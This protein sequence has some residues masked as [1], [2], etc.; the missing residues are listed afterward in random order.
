MDMD[1]GAVHVEFVVG[2][3]AVGHAVPSQLPFHKYS[4][5][6]HLSLKLTMFLQQKETGISILP[7]CFST[8]A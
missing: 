2:K 5:F 6:S 1:Y 4:I 7:S 8:G 3:V